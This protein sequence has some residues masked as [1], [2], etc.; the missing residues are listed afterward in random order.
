MSSVLFL[1]IQLPRKG[2][3]DHPSSHQVSK[4]KDVI[5][6]EIEYFFVAPQPQGKCNWLSELSKFGKLDLDFPPLE[7]PLH[8]NA[9]ECVW[10]RLMVRINQLIFHDR[11]CHHSLIQRP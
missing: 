9:A 6:H 1:V 2:V 5:F 4:S 10:N 3:T 7:L 11:Q 8:S